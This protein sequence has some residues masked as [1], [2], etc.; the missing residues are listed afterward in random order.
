MEDVEMNLRAPYFLLGMKAAACDNCR[1]STPVF[2]LV[3]GA[4]HSLSSPADDDEGAGT[5]ETATGHALLFHVDAVGLVAQAQL[6][7]LAPSF[8]RDAE[9]PDAGW[10]NH[11]GQCQE[12]LPDSE[13]FCEPGGAFL[14]TSVEA[15]RRIEFLHVESSFEARAAGYAYE[16]AFI[17]FPV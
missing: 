11:C 16:P 9:A 2:A 6:A 4:G 12:A 10:V 5:W 15:A 1:S 17:A 7:R 13:L 3:L 14:P 8:H